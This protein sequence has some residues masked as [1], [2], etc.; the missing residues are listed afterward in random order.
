MIFNFLL[1]GF[2]FFFFLHFPNL[3]EYGTYQVYN[4]KQSYKR[5][6]IEYLPLAE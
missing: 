2:W 3:F 5:N 6:G 1:M 4:I